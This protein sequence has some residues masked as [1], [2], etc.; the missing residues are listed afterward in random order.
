MS[1]NEKIRNNDAGFYFKKIA[2][3]LQAYADR[4]GFR[5]DVTYAQGKVLF[6][7]H[8]QSDGA[9]AMKEI[10]RYLDVSHATVSGIVSRL[11]EKGLVTCEKSDKDARAKL[12][13]LTETENDGFEEMKRRRSELEEMLLNGFSVEERAT[14]KRNLAR[15]YENVNSIPCD[16]G[17]NE[18]EK[19]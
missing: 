1:E 15:I 4:R 7:L 5:H 9:A 16:F 17:E 14:M 18:R 11:S 2:E 3:R 12:V 8:E 10:E 19:N 6:F 13:R